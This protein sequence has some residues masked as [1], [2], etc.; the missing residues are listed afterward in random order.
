MTPTKLSDVARH[1]GVSLS[2]AG[3]VLNG[4]SDGIRVGEE[5]RKRIMAAA[6]EL[7]YRRNVAASVL[8]GGNSNL[9]GVIADTYAHY[10]T[11]AVFQAVEQ[12]AAA[13]GLRLMTCSA[14]DNIRN[15]VESYRDFRRHFSARVLMLA[16]DYPGDEQMIRAAFQG[17]SNVVFLDPPCFDGAHWVE[18]R[19]FTA[20]ERLVRCRLG[21]GRRRFGILHGSLK[22]G[23]NRRLVEDFDA[24]LRAAGLDPS[25]QWHGEITRDLPV[26][27][28]CRRIAAEFGR[29][30]APQVL[31]VDKTEH[32]VALQGR[33]QACGWRI[34]EDLEFVCGD[35]DPLHDLIFPEMVSFDPG[36]PAIAGALLEALLEPENAPP[37]R[38]IEAEFW[39]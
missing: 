34:P 5:A 36:Y 19:N 38:V 26:H 14:H 27:E 32:A 25:G 20:L 9:L 35:H 18:M 31:F 1:A 16:H 17:E 6:A 37:C 21:A 29:S 7:G 13:R 23:Y 3:K 2:A 12:A 39:A 8:R 15:L 11:S 28:T 24:A 30:G 4:G 33:L 10:R 22:Y